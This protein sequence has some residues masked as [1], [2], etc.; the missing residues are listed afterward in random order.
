MILTTRPKTK[1]CNYHLFRLTLPGTCS[2]QIT[3]LLK[4]G[5]SFGPSLSSSKVPALCAQPDHFVEYIWKGATCFIRLHHIACIFSM[6]VH[7]STGMLLCLLGELEWLHFERLHAFLLARPSS[8]RTGK[9]VSKPSVW[10][11]SHTGEGWSLNRR[12]G[13]GYL[14]LVELYFIGGPWVFPWLFNFQSTIHSLFL[15]KK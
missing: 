3:P 4:G 8:R 10:E 2:I 12:L 9:E 6:C 11:A 1:D 13:N 14:A 7:M 5:S 15:K